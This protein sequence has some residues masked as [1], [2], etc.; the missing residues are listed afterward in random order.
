MLIPVAEDAIRVKL[1]P[2]GAKPLE[3]LIFTEKVP[4]PKYRVQKQYG[5]T[6]LSTSKMTVTYVRRFQ[7]L[8]FEDADGNELLQDK[9]RV[10]N[11]TSV[12]GKRT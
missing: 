2:E 10:L 3:E 1:V 4:M 5:N 9:L 11:P 12:Q 7:V 8:I 6:I